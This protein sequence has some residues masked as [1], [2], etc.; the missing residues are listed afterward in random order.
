MSG[1]IE[2]QVSWSRR[3]ISFLLRSSHAPHHMLRATQLQEQLRQIEN[4]P[5]DEAGPLRARQQKL[6]FDYRRVQKLF[7]ALK[8]EAMVTLEAAGIPRYDIFA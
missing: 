3:D 6:N 1:Q 4:R 7:A 8:D 2:L 5:R